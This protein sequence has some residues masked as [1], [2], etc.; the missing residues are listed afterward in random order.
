MQAIDPFLDELK[1]A[2]LAGQQVLAANRNRASSV[3]AAAE[4]TGGF[5]TAATRLLRRL[6]Q[7]VDVDS[8]A[9][10]GHGAH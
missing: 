1:R 2:Q 9:F 4:V 8:S 3:P 5:L 7:R 10:P 6:F